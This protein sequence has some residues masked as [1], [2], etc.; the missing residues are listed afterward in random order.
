M[1]KHEIREAA[2]I[3][4]YQMELTGQTGEEI[5][6]STYEAFGMPS[7]KAV[8]SLANNVWEKK[9]ELD[10][11]IG[12]YSPTRSAS[13]ISKVNIT[14]LRIAVYELTYEKEKVPPKVAI[15]EAVELSKAYAEKNDRAF[16]NGVLN[17]YF[18]D[19]G[20]TE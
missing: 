17:S 16:I 7:N 11:V 19:T 1:T 13:R 12:K 2:F 20:K 4:L 15:N 3:I 14:I 18:K 6:D 5:A 9:E 10:G 8:I